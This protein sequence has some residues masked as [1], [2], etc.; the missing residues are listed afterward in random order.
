GTP[1]AP[2]TSPARAHRLSGANGVP[3]LRR[4]A[5]QARRGRDRD[6]GARPGALEGGPARAREVLLPRLRGDHTTTGTLA[7]DRARPRRPRAAGADPVLE[8]RRAPAAPSAERD[9][10]T[11]RCRAR[12]LDP[13][14]LG[15]A[16]RGDA[17]AAD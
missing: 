11:R 16:G 5:T 17:R 3:V 2:G 4:R 1:A 12:C 10:G 6:V 7:P 13:R 15:R 8:I 9:L 14:R